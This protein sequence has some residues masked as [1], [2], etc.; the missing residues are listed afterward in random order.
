MSREVLLFGCGQAVVPR[1]LS[2]TPLSP[3]C[4]ALPSVSQA[5]VCE[6]KLRALLRELTAMREKDP[7]SKVREACTAAVHGSC[8]RHSAF[9]VPV[10]LCV[11]ATQLF[12]VAASRCKRNGAEHFVPVVP[13]LSYQCTST[14]GWLPTMC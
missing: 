4:V 3:S 6:S 9:H 13:S 8:A 12:V 7:T 5:V 14:G 2:Y 1:L 11:R 10:Q